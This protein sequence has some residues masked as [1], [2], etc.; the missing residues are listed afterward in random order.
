MDS[1][2]HA[3]DCTLE[4]PFFFLL[5]SLSMISLVVYTSDVLLCLLYRFRCGIMR[6]DFATRSTSVNALVR[7]GHCF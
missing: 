3:F 1:N 7:L 4:R 2:L 6:P 5:L